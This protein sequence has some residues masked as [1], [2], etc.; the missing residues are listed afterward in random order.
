MGTPQRGVL[1]PPLFN[2]LMSVIAKSHTRGAELIIYADDIAVKT[3]NAATTH[4]VLSNITKLCNS[5]GL[6]ISTDKTKIIPGK[7]CANETYRMQGHEIEKVNQYKY[8]GVIITKSRRYDPEVARVK[9]LCTSKLNILKKL[10]L[11]TFG[12]TVGMLK[13][14]YISLVRSIIDYRASYFTGLTKKQFQDLEVLQNKALRIILG[15]PLCCNVEMMRLETCLPSIQK[16]IREVAAGQIFRTISDPYTLR[17]R[18][19]PQRRD[20]L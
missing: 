20:N 14:A 8:M 6:I 19:F 3:K 13:R 4:K 9:G 18:I 16:R 7:G 17:A 10:V 15:T 11:G 2:V 5:V 12:S 1:S